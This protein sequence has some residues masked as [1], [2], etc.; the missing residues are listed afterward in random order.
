MNRSPLTCAAEAIV[1]TMAVGSQKDG[2]DES[3]RQKGY[4]L[5][6]ALRHITTHMLIA[7][8]HQPPD[9]EFHLRHAITRLAM[10]LAIEEE[11]DGSPDH[12]DRP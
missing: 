6:K 7:D 2:R 9:G 3:W 5:Q 1:E 12:P 8:G 4:H 11:T 10:Q